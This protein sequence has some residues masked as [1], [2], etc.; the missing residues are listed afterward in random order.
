MISSTSEYGDPCLSQTN[1]Q[2]LVQY[3]CVDSNS[4]DRISSCPLD[5]NVPSNCPKIANNITIEEFTWCEPTTMQIVCPLRQVIR[6]NC[7]FYGIDPYLKCSG[8][9]LGAPTSCYSTAAV[10][11][12]N[13]ACS[14]RRTCSVSGNPS[15]A[16][17]LRNVCPGYSNI[18]YVQWECVSSTA[19]TAQMQI[20]TA[21]TL[22]YC[23]LKIIPSGK[24][25]TSNPYVPAF[26]TDSTQKSFGYPIS[27]IIACAGK[28][29]LNCPTNTVIHIYSAYY[30]IQ[31][32]TMT[33]QCLGTLTDIPEA[34]YYQSTF[35]IISS[36]CE[37]QQTCSVTANSATLGGTDICPDYPQ[38]QLFIQYQCVDN[39]GLNST[40]NK[41]PLNSELPPYCP[42]KSSNLQESYFCSGQNI[43][44]SCTSN[45]NI[46]IS[47]GFY[48]IHPSYN[49]CNTTSIASRPVCYFGDTLVILKNLCQ[50]KFR[51]DLTDLSMF[52][53]PCS[54]LTK[55]LYIQWECV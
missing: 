14:G 2:L 12:I 1:E 53:D 35:D 25:P 20:S 22:P 50:G 23:D 44:L 15:F 5:K 34:C 3:Q 52:I 47:C 7:A 16:N 29:V 30:G 33:S 13:T 43:T 19:T 36:N 11:I 32:K 24:C 54:G 42:A 10:N 26:L 4:Y 49:Y 18:L 37:F 38:K 31:S 9:T 8:F 39:Y 17:T 27:E 46:S 51:C 21:S 48:G 40:I 41:C 55:V 28:I 45:K 6:I